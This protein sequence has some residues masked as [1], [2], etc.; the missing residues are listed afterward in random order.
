MS[1]TSRTLLTAIHMQ[2]LDAAVVALKRQML[3]PIQSTFDKVSQIFSLT[4]RQI[5]C[6]LYLR[7][8]SWLGRDPGKESD[9]GQFQI[10]PPAVNF[11]L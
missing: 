11:K 10:N 4:P 1:A 8:T 2:N 6:I 5:A 3:E 9:T 7:Q